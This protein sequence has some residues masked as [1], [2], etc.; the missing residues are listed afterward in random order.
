MSS[1]GK[2]STLISSFNIT[3][4]TNFQTSRQWYK[5]YYCWCNVV[6]IRILFIQTHQCIVII[7]SDEPLPRFKA[8]KYTIHIYVTRTRYIIMIYLYDTRQ[9][10]SSPTPI[11][12]CFSLINSCVCVYSV[13]TEHKAKV[14]NYYYLSRIHVTTRLIRNLWT[15]RIPL[16]GGRVYIPKRR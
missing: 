6:N 16:H 11:R 1:L 15:R 12:S 3:K 2:R 9:S 5:D 14:Y 8:A 4:S 13:N 10:P 7:S